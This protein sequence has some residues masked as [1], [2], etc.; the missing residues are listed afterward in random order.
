M[1]DLATHLDE[2]RARAARILLAVPLLDA[3]TEPDGF[4]VVVRHEAWLTAWFESTC[5]WPLVVDAA[6]G[7]ARLTKRSARPDP[8]RPLRRTRG[9][10]APFDRRRY[11][12]LC[13]VCAEL[14]RHPVTTVGLLAGAVGAAADLDTARKSERVA[15]VD[16]LRA[17]MGWGALTATAGDIES[18]ADN[19]T[20]NAILTADTARLHRLLS[21][22]TTP[23]SV[24]DGANSGVATD[25]LLAEPRYGDAPGDTEMA[26]EEQRLRWIRHQLARR[27]IDDPVTYVEDLTDQEK[28]YLANPAGRRWLREHVA[29]AGF[30]LEERTEGLIAVDPTGRC[31]DLLFPAPHGNAHQLALLLVDR[32]LVTG[33][34]GERRPGRVSAAELRRFVEDLLERFPGWARSARDGDGVERLTDEA[35]DIL[36]CFDLAHRAPTGDVVGRPALARYRAGEPTVSGDATL[37]EEAM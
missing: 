31:S 1:P 29:A 8:T 7:F 19:E 34:S 14:V 16:A 21:S 35:V 23:T 9:S 25:A 15:F 3:G 24:P 28:E 18:F 30:E 2:E 6:G 12:L 32:L 37:F 26:D 17:L 4:R 22:A 11:Q 13:L 33:A 36:A 20:G 27:L 10:G 5:G